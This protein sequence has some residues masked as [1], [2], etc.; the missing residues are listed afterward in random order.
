MKLSIHQQ[1]EVQYIEGKLGQFLTAQEA[2]ELTMQISDIAVEVDEE[3]ARV[4][5]DPLVGKLYEYDGQFF[6]PRGKC[7]FQ[8]AFDGL[9]LLR[10]LGNFIDTFFKGKSKQSAI[11]WLLDELSKH[12]WAAKRRRM[13]WEEFS[14]LQLV[15]LAILQGIIDAHGRLRESEN[16]PPPLSAE[17]QAFFKTFEQ[18]FPGS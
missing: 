14:T 8:T 17:E 1:T 7:G 11:R 10:S 3:I 2:R 5:R 4:L 16:T 9:H 15:P 18:Q 13:N 12:S 6:T